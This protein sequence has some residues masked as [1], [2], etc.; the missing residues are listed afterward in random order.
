LTDDIAALASALDRAS[1]RAPRAAGAAL[2]EAADAIARDVRANVSR[3]ISPRFAA[4]VESR[5]EADF[6]RGTPSAYVLLSRAPLADGTDPAAVINA[7]E[8][9]G[10]ARAPRPSI[11]PA[12]ERHGPGVAA[13]IAELAA[14]L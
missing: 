2:G 11:L 5:R 8:V 4:A 7:Y 9:G 1:R 10:A 14:D 3:N 12:V 13:R 6:P